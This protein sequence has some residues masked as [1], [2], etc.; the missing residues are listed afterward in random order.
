MLKV[1]SLEEF[2]QEIEYIIRT[3]DCSVIEAICEYAES[4]DIDF[5]SLVPYINQS[6]KE[7]IQNEAEGKNLI[8]KTDGQLPF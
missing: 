8:K 4:R 3:D 2:K 1:I 5:K 7:V 6:F